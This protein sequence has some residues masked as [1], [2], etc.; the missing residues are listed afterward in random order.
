MNVLGR[1]VLVN[2]IHSQCIVQV[3][4]DVMHQAVHGGVVEVKIVLIVGMVVPMADADFDRQRVEVFIDIKNVLK[5]AGKVGQGRLIQYLDEVG[6]IAVVIRGLV[7]FQ[8]V[9][10]PAAGGEFV[11]VRVVG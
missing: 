8:L 1:P 10:T 9:C 3:V 11:I 7:G 6:Q 2:P 4:G 5:C